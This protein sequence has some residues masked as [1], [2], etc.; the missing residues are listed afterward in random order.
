[1]SFPQMAHPYEGEKTPAVGGPGWRRGNRVSKLRIASQVTRR[2][3]P[4]TMPRGGRDGPPDTA[5]CQKHV[6]PDCE[7]TAD[8]GRFWKIPGPDP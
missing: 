8:C 5:Q 2:V 6:E 7:E 3:P 4:G 1:M